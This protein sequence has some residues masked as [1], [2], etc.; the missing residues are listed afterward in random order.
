MYPNENNI[1]IIQVEYKRNKKSYTP[2]NRNNLS[3]NFTMHP[4]IP[5]NTLPIRNIIPDTTCTNT[6]TIPTRKDMEIKEIIYGILTQIPILGGI[7]L[8]KKL[9]DIENKIKETTHK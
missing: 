1:S 2:N 4:G 9:I 3:Y 8:Y 5:H 7:V 6:H